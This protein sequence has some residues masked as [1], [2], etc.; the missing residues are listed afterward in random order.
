[1]AEQATHNCLVGGSSPSPRTNTNSGC[2]FATAFLYV[3]IRLVC[4]TY[5]QV[6]SQR[7]RE[8][9]MYVFVNSI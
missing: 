4:N 2:E 9:V 6:E 8:A 3:T 5:A 1:M 7:I